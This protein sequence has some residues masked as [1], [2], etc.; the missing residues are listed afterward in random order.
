MNGYEL[1][2]IWFNWC[3]ENP[4]LINTNHT[5]LYFFCIEHCNRLGWKQKFGL[6]TTM[7]KEALGIRS[8]NTYKKTLDDLVKFGFIDLIEI[9]KNQYSSNII[10]LS[11]FDK[12]LDEALDKAIGKHTIKQSESIGESNSSIDKL[13]NIR[14]KELK[15]DDDVKAKSSL[16]SSTLFSIQS[17]NTEF[18]DQDAFLLMATRKTGH[19]VDQIKEF[20]KLFLIDQ[21][22]VNK[23]A[24]QSEA[25]MRTHFVNWINKQPKQSVKP[26]IKESTL[27][28]QKRE[29][30]EQLKKQIH[31][32]K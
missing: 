9:S 17:I 2:R 14:T 13:K 26:Q 32:Q 3:F 4:D 21:K 29:A 8:Y 31:G 19:K 20:F 11:K 25:D 22:G 10:A 1:S 24:W 6:P 7:A 18:L 28:R 30:E 27:A 16:P 12:A 5:A 23:I 15:N